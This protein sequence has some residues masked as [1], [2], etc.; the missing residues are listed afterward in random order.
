MSN[1]DFDQFGSTSSG[2]S[3]RLGL[4]A[5]D[6]TSPDK[7][8][9]S[10]QTTASPETA[11]PQSH[12]PQSP[13][14]PHPEG[15]FRP[16]VRA[17]TGTEKPPVRE[18]QI[19]AAPDYN[20]LNGAS[21]SSQSNESSSS[22]ALNAQEGAARKSKATLYLSV[23]PVAVPPV[24]APPVAA[25]PT[26]AHPAR[27]E[28]DLNGA[29]ETVPTTR[30]A[31]PQQS[32][33]SSNSSA[34]ASHEYSN[35]APLLPSSSA[36]LGCDTA[37]KS[38]NSK[39]PTVRSSSRIKYFLEH[40][41]LS[42]FIQPPLL[43]ASQWREEQREEAFNQQT[44]ELFRLRLRLVAGMAMIMLLFHTLLYI[45]LTPGN[46]SAHTVIYVSLLTICI[47]ARH[48]A[49]KLNSV[50]ALIQ[51]S[52]WC[53]AL[54]SLGG[55]L[56]VG[57]I[58]RDQ[59][60]LLGGHNHILLTTMLLPFAAAHCFFVG[61][62][63]IASLMVSGFVTFMPHH[64]ELY[65]SQLFTLCTTMAFT[66]FV[67]YFQNTLRRRA[68]DSAFDAMCAM[69]RYQDM[70]L[71][72]T[73]TGGHNR[74]FL[75]QTLETEIARSMRFSRPISLILFDLDNFKS[76]NDTLGHA[77]GDEVLIEVWCAATKAVRNVDT[78]ARYGGDEF[79]IVLPEAA[80][81]AAHEIATRLRTTTIAHLLNRFGENSIQ[82]KVTL[83]I[84]IVTLRPYDVITAEQLLFMAD[85]QLYAAK[86]AGKN[87]IA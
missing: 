27:R 66:V 62:M 63:V 81:D 37:A 31:N 9:A 61:S 78:P 14:A 3:H 18:T 32:N 40:I 29:P 43:G 44:M 76:V 33:L 4:S 12:Q 7:T 57:V 50:G 46:T 69:S 11:T 24:A 75:M 2:D 1:S 68:F 45:Y 58:G 39:T 74:R 59:M 56:I 34:N 21:S 53:Y 52:L 30:E 23:P 15:V 22:C 65:F 8:T 83:S 38:A 84:G 49:Q 47:T 60:F 13:Y 77:A 35:Q 26:A 17:K 55:A 67:A 73:L 72:D 79:A 86:K 85:T 25:P 6:Q 54:F 87:R 80:E 20:A 10:H 48:L 5:P 82:A 41:L 51:L 16:R 64:S 28:T 36:P 71:R 42:H 70:S 19:L